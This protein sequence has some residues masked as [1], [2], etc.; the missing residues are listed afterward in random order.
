MSEKTLFT[1][2]MPT[3][4]TVA[5]VGVAADELSFVFPQKGNKSTAAVVLE[6]DK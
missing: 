6:S 4:Q 5:N 3:L 1:L 2:P